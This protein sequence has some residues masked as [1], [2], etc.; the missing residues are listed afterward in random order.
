MLRRRKTDADRIVEISSR[1]FTTLVEQVMALRTEVRDAL[2]KVEVGVRAQER[3]AQEARA[4]A[5]RARR[6]EKRAVEAAAASAA[7]GAMAA[8]AHPSVV[9]QPLHLDAEAVG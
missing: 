5:N 2:T 4:S 9:D 3:A 8:P 7:A 1:D 6:H